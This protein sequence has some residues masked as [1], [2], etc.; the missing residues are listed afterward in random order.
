MNTH[1]NQTMEKRVMLIQE[2]V[3]I[4]S[5]LNQLQ[6]QSLSDQEYEERSRALRQ[7]RVDLTRELTDLAGKNGK[8]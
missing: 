3:G 6:D 7:R 8:R 5:V 1:D 4:G 2:L